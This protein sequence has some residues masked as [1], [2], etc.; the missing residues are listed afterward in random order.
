MFDP[1]EITIVSGG[2]TGADRAALDFAI[3]MKLD[4]FVQ[5]RFAPSAEH[6]R[7]QPASQDVQEAHGYVLCSTRLT[8]ADSRSHLAISVSSCLRPAFVSE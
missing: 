8:P 4:F 3:E 7:L 5:I 6:D 1:R 2:Q